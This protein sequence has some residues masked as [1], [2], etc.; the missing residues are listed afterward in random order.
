M[1]QVRTPREICDKQT[2][3]K[4]YTVA[5]LCRIFQA[6]GSLF[7]DTLKSLDLPAPTGKA[8]LLDAK[9]SG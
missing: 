8:F 5:K 3:K 2:P 7:D 9:L 1:G 4:Q 6:K